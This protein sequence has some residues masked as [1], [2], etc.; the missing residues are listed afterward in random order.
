MKSAKKTSFYKKIMN[1]KLDVVKNR[2][3]I[4]IPPLVIMLIGMII[5]ICF[6]FNKGIDFT[7]GTVMNVLPKTQD[8]S[9]SAEFNN[10]KDKI[11]NV[12]T[13]NGVI[14]SY[15]QI[16]ETDAG[17]AISFRFQDKSGLTEDSTNDL[18]AKIRNELFVAFG[19]DASQDSA[20][21]Q[22]AQRISPTASGEFLMN[23]FLSILVAGVLILIYIEFRFELATG[24]SAIL[25]LLHDVLITCSFVLIF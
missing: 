23:A 3:A 7:G 8:M 24:L 6:G 5:L 10:A 16:A 14:A 11:N 12:L 4:F 9:I 20:Y 15:F 17:K 2:K 1:S 18:N 22:S 13:A 25:T 21:I 19:M